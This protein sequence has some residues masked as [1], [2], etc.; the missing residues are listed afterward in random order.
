MEGRSRD[1][2][3]R[4][5]HLGRLLVLASAGALL[6]A[7][8]RRK[9]QHSR[10]DG[11]RTGAAIL[12]GS[13]L[14]DSAMEHF[15]GG[16]H[17]R[18]MYAAPAAALVSLAAS[19]RGGQGGRLGHAVALGTGLAGLFFH[20]RSVIRRPGG[21]CWNNLFYAA[22]IGAPGALVVGGLLGLAGEHAARNGTSRGEARALTGLIGAAL[23]GETA[24]VWLLHLRGAYHNPFM[25]LPVVI[26]P[27]AGAAL[28]GQALSPRPDPRHTRQLLR[29]TSALGVL[30]TGFHIIGVQRNM[31][32]W[33]N[34]RQTA[35]AGPPVPAPIS[36]TGLALAGG[37]ALDRLEGTHGGAAER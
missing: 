3:R 9:H 5:R 6:A 15:R 20:A 16:W 23:W 7:G 29:A 19:R 37:A 34:W 11:L 18:R 30:G 25:Y 32:G 28:M 8:V 2:V 27:L 35:L 21:V 24:E 12:A 26:P 10:G 1:G 33:R 22:P 36:F 31:G 17:D 14:L 4:P 13:V